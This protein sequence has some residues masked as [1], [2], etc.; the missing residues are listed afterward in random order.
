[1]TRR[2]PKGPGKGQGGGGRHNANSLLNLKRDGTGAPLGNQQT[3]RHGARSALLVADVSDEIVEVM[4]GIAD[5]CPV[6]DGDGGLPDAD[7]LS[8]EACAAA[9]K[10]YRHVRAYCDLHGRL[11]PKGKQT[12][13]ADYEMRSERA[14]VAALKALGLDPESR[15]R[16]GLALAHTERALTDA[17]AEGRRNWQAREERDRGESA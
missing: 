3:L 6:R 2:R 13:A 16:L 12:S 8:V 1:M 9:L 15:A 4:Q 11:D 17:M 5:V 7:V 10:R 14:F